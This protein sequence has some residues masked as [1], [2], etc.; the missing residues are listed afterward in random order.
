MIDRDIAISVHTQKRNRF[1]ERRDHP[2][3]RTVLDEGIVYA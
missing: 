3:N 1:E 2:F